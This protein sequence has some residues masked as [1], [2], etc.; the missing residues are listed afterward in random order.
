MNNSSSEPSV[1][2]EAIYSSKLT[3][4][5]KNKHS[6]DD[7]ASEFLLF[8]NCVVCLCVEEAYIRRL[9]VESSSFDSFG[10]GGY[11]LYVSTD[12][13]VPMGANGIISLEI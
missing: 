6:I 11:L 10:L 12:E 1:S 7:M 3:G 8:P 4:T 5:H 2:P 9:L 13:E